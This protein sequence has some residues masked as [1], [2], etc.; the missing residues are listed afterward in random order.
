V[1]A[2]LIVTS[3]DRADLQVGIQLANLAD[4]VK[5]LQCKGEGDAMVALINA[6]WKASGM[7]A[8]L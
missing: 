5:L 6:P 1:R 2:G 7:I 3:D 4:G 8:V